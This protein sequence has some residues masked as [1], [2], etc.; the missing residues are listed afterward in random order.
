M[1][2]SL[3]SNGNNSAHILRVMRYQLSHWLLEHVFAM[4]IYHQEYISMPYSSALF[5]TETT[6]PIFSELYDI[7]FHFGCMKTYLTSLP[8]IRKLDQCPIL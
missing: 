4:G 7:S 8:G 1:P 3:S 2:Y 5:Q 6:M